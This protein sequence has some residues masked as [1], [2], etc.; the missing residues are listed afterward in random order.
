M[1]ILDR[2]KS[3]PPK[4]TTPTN[5]VLNPGARDLVDQIAPGAMIVHHDAIH[6]AG[7]SWMR[8]WFV[9]DLPP[10]MERGA[11]DAIYDFTGEI[12]VSMLVRPLD[13]S[14]VREQLRQQRTA[15][16]AEVIT[17]SRQGRLP[18]Y[19]AEEEL[20]ETE[21]TLKDLEASHLPPQELLW[22]IALYTRDEHEL[23]EQSRRLEDTLLDA[24]LRFFRAA[25][26]QEDALYSVQPF[27]RNFLG[28]GRNITPA[29]LAAMFPFSRRLQADARGIPYGIDRSTGTWV[30]VDDFSLPN[31]NLLILGEQGSGK[32]MFLKYK[33]TWAVLLGM[34]CY[35][36][37]LEG[38]FEKMC[39]A[40]GGTYLD[41]S[42]SSPHHM[43]IMDLNT[44]EM[45]A[46]QN[47]LQDVMS[48]IELAMGELT[49]YE[50]NVILIPAY[51]RVMT[52]AGILHN[53]KETWKQKP[54]VLTDL[55]DVLRSEEN[56]V[57]Q[58]LAARLY[59]IASGVYA[60]AFSS[61]TNINPRS[62]L[63][64]FGLKDVHRDFQALRMRQ[65]QTFIW[66]NVLS[67][68]HPTLVVVDEA[69]RW[70]RQKSA[71][72]DLA[73]MAR[74]FRKRYAGLHLATQHGSDLSASESA[75]VIRDT[76]AMVMLFRQAPSGHAKLAELFGLNEVEAAE[77]LTLDRGES[78]LIKGQQH[79]PVYTVI[80]PD[81]YATWT[82]DPR[83]Q[84]ADGK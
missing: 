58:D 61:R 47:G 28:H 40:L 72:E 31:S 65:V 64:V 74:R 76:A 79:I 19:L 53:K 3:S 56:P 80:P 18:D 54:P 75:V 83:E 62:P 5:D 15:L 2:F 25:L 44:D 51:Q 26:R 24:D 21:R 82:T 38:E 73:E 67:K 70:L 78:V 39:H 57:A 81:W 32:S 9:Q 17:R 41:L 60:E 6:L 12:R 68:M 69:W 16:H 45:D 43:N 7:E 49:A 29:A 50:R 84:V 42:L 36:L 14:A 48:W 4:V 22:V 77:L 63:V 37:D 71:A 11:L 13:K 59:Q 33:A 66:A 1:N 30:I 23:E 46:W 10:Q 52:E 27:G 8:V 34:R 35:I 20:A 55:Y